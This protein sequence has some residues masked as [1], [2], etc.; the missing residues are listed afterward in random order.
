VGLLPEG[1]PTQSVGGSQFHPV[2]SSSSLLSRIVAKK[3]SP[4]ESIAFDRGIYSF[5]LSFSIL[6]A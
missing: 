5:R 4:R 3:S 2:I 6:V 1:G